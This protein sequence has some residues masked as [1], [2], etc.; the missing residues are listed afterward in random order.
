MS[1]FPIEKGRDEQKKGNA[2][3]FTAREVQTQINDPFYNTR[4]AN[5]NK[6]QNTYRT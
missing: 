5:S 2:T 4:G 3:H 1:D 6:S